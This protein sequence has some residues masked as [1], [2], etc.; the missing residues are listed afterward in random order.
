M[1]YIPQCFIYSK[2]F[3]KKGLAL[4]FTMGILVNKLGSSLS[5][6]LYPLLYNVNNS[7]SLPLFVGDMLC[8]FSFICSISVAILD[9]NEDEVGKEMNL[10]VSQFK[11]K[12]VIFWLFA[13]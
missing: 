3:K 8:V 11:F 12:N 13:V 6:I 7:L 2:W 10:N 4:A 5:G 1:S 9:K